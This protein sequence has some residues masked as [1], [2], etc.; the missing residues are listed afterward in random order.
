MVLFFLLYIKSRFF[1]SKIQLVLEHLINSFYPFFKQK[2]FRILSRANSFLSCFIY[3]ACIIQLI[4]IIIPLFY[5]IAIQFFITFYLSGF[6]MGWDFFYFGISLS[7]T[8][9]VW[10]YGQ[11]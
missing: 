10:F 7:W 1:P 3:Y 8:F 5:P 6:V 2:P 11:F 9:L 4:T